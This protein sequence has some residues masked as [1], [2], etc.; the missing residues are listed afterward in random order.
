[1]LIAAFA[2]AAVGLVIGAITLRLR[3]I[4]FSL[5]TFAIAGVFISWLTGATNITGG[6]NGLIAMP[7][8]LVDPERTF[9]WLGLG[10]SILFF[11]LQWILLSSRWGI[12]LRAVRDRE[13]VANGLGVRV[14]MVK[15]A[16]F[17]YTAFW[18]G[19]AG[20]FYAAYV[21]FITPSLGAISNI[22]LVIA[23]AVVGGLGTM[24]GPI[25][26][27]L[28]VRIIEYYTRGYGGEFTVLIFSAILL[29]IMLFMRDGIVGLLERAAMQFGGRRDRWAAPTGS[30]P[31]GGRE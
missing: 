25:V 4:Y 27:T 11:G 9:V 10:L 28:L 18:A 17:T 26:G 3:T 6:S 24:T 31:S 29:A 7:L 2:T 30:Q 15:V 16:T 19:A 23:M 22:G 14:T 13:D 1:M 20:A 21:G 12:L 5:A 8:V